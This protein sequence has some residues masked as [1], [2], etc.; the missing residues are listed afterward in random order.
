MIF[1]LLVSIGYVLNV[2]LL[3]GVFDVPGMFPD[4]ETIRIELDK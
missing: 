4:I 1:A 2:L 3:L